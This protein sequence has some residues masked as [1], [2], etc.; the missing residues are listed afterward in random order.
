MNIVSPVPRGSGV[1]VL[2]RDLARC[3]PG[4]RLRTYSPWLSLL[5]PALRLLSG[6]DAGLVHA[7]ADYG[8]FF[9]RAG[10]PLVVTLHNYTS[11]RFMAPFSSRLQYLHYRSDLR[12]FSRATLTRANA[13]VAIS[14]F[15]GDLVRQDL[16]VDPPMRTI[17]NGVDHERF[18]PSNS[19]RKP[20]PFRVLFCGNLNR[21][22]RAHLLPQLA[23]ALDDRFEI[24]YTAGLGD[25]N[26]SKLRID[27]AGARLRPL[28]RIE[29]A[30]MPAVYQSMDAL[31]MP[32]VREGFGL[33]VAEAMA[34]GLPVVACRESALPELVEP[35]Q[36]GMLCA[37]DDVAAFAAALRRL[38]DDPA[39]ASRMGEFNRARVEQ[40]FTLERMVREYSELFEAVRDG[41]FS[42]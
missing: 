40:V 2:H 27:P 31:F 3:I 15:V 35:G 7:S 28:G 8:V 19:R 11:D 9:A 4:Y 6:R 29:H 21:R 14:R 10:V 32:S 5:P 13:V 18:V 23:A 39:Q 16:G 30:A 36:G 42:R 12:W 20:R 22:K 26:L 1:E 37:V 17:Y 38:A 41:A 24:C 25:G 34:C 33:C